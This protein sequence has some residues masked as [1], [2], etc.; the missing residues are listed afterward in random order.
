MDVPIEISI[1]D[2]TTGLYYIYNSGLNFM[3]PWRLS[4]SKSQTIILEMTESE[5]QHATESFSVKC[6]WMLEN[7][8]FSSYCIR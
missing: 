7:T 6:G 4:R 3:V 8:N 1:E 5:L 2:V